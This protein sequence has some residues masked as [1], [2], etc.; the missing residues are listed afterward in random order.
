MKVGLSRPR[1]FAPLSYLIRLFLGT[2]YSHTYVEI[3]EV[4]Y[5]AT[6]RGVVKAD[7][8]KFLKKNK[9]VKEYEFNVDK[10]EVLL[11]CLL[12]VGKKYGYLTL[13][14]ILL[15]EMFGIKIGN[16]DNK[17]F[18]CSEF[19]GMILE[20]VFDV[21]LGDQNYFTPKDIEEKIEWISYKKL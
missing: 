16:D 18:I 21:E 9:V 13:L 8:N 6:G 2:S 15:K 12:Y 7:K 3:D 10:V 1:G 14:G 17:T 4:I 5:H 20:I 19:V 11:I